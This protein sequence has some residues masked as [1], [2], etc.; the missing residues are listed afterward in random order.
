MASA[1]SVVLWARSTANPDPCGYY[2][3]RVAWFSVGDSTAYQYYC[4]GQAYGYNASGASYNPVNNNVYDAFTNFQYAYYNNDPTGGNCIA[5]FGPG[6]QYYTP[7]QNASPSL[8]LVNLVSTNGGDAFNALAVD[9]G[10]TSSS[11]SDEFNYPAYVNLLMTCTGY[12]VPLSCTF[13]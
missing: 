6:E 3:E 11:S 10:Y 2:D 5:T 13:L 9:L 1:T 4:T 12:S 7:D 8:T